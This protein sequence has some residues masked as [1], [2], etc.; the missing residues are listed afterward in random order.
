MALGITTAGLYYTS[1]YYAIFAP[2][3]SATTVRGPIKLHR[4]LA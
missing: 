1:S 3:I 4:T 2:K